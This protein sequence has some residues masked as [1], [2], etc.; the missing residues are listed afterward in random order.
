[1]FWSVWSPLT[2]YYTH[3]CLHNHL[4]KYSFSIILHFCIIL[5]LYLCRKN[6]QRVLFRKTGQKNTITVHILAK[7]TSAEFG[8]T[9]FSVPEGK[10]IYRIVYTMVGESF[11]VVLIVRM[12]EF[13]AKVH[14][15]VRYLFYNIQYL[16]FGHSL[17]SAFLID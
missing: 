15:E 1:M 9:M 11:E 5:L 6:L 16:T 13:A 14:L 17:K 10:R 2:P 7:Q 4:V 12:L 8:W 3:I